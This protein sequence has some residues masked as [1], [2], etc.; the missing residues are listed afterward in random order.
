MAAGG[1]AHGAR[2]V[3][4]GGC[5]VMSSDDMA[6]VLIVGTISVS[7][8]AVRIAYWISYWRSKGRS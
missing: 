5:G 7:I 4:A 1:E 6:L 8:A 2:C 3:W